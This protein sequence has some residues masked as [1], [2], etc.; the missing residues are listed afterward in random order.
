MLGLT[1]PTIARHIEALELGFGLK[2]FVRSQQ[3]LSPTDGALELKHLCLVARGDF[4]GNDARRFR[5]C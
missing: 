4:R 5:A 3:G 2:L 1:Q